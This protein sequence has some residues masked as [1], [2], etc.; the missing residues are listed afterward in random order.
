MR[1]EH[2]LLSLVCFKRFEARLGMLPDMS[3]SSRRLGS[4][5]V[6]PFAEYCNGDVE[7]EVVGVSI[8]E[9]ALIGS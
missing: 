7:R 6:D 2:L 4:L 3:P 9:E 1:T 8:V 5:K